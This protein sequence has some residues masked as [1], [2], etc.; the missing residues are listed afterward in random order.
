MLRE[1]IALEWKTPV[2]VRVAPQIRE[3]PPELER[4][5]PPMV[6]EAI[7]NALKHGE[8]SRV[9]VDVESDRRA[10]RI[11]V[12]D[13]GCGFPFKGRYDHATLAERR[14]GP[15]SLCERTASLGGQVTVESEGTGARV[16]IMLPL[17]GAA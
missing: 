1:R 2:T 9:W 6:H 14:I 3:L 7:V 13:D 16:E 17:A 11:I 12:G 4:A 15:A 10:L 8:P 5:V